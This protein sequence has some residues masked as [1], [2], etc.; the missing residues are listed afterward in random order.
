M[1]AENMV[2]SVEPGIYLKG[3]GG[4]R[5]SDTVLV[6]QNGNECSTRHASDIESL[7]V[8]GWKPMTRLKGLLIQRATGLKENAALGA[9]AFE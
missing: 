5:D 6:T 9:I 1:L 2:I 3:Q 8:L 4:F 7:T